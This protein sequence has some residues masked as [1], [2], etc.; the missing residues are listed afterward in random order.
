MGLRYLQQELTDRH[1]E[2]YER[3]IQVES[4][5]ANEGRKM[6]GWLRT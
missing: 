6:F 2:L 1:Q 4:S 5:G 3:S